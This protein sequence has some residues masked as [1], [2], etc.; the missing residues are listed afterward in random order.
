MNDENGQS[1]IELVVAIG[2]FVI[3]A[4]SLAFLIFNSYT[5]GFLASDITKANF[6]AE[7]GLE[8][9]RSIRDNDWQDLTSGNYSLDE[10]SG[11]WEFV[12]GPELINGKFT[13]TIMVEDFIP[14]DPGRKKVT[15]KVA[16]QFPEDRP[17]EVSL[18]THLTNWQMVPPAPFCTGACTSCS[19]ILDKKTCDEQDGCSWDKKLKICLDDPGCTPCDSYTTESDCIA[20]DGCQWVTP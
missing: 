15:S 16:W 10:S 19:D 17:Q 6:L 1:L 2:I 18:V 12:P 13:R 4:S 9:V 8:A 7:E 5:A 20:Q 3:V 14:L 11:S